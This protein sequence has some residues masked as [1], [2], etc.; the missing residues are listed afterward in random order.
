MFYKDQE[1]LILEITLLF[2]ALIRIS[3]TLCSNFSDK[4]MIIF[5]EIINFLIV[6]LF[7]INHLNYN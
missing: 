7:S 5:N 2:M 3:I 4:F 1:W 6:F